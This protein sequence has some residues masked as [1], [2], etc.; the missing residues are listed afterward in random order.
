MKLAVIIHAGV[1]VLS[2]C[3]LRADYTVRNRG[4]WPKTWPTELESLRQH[5]TE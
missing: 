3:P 1:I 5:H 2:A 4:A